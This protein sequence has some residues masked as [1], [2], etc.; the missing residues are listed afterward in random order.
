MISIKTSSLCFPLKK[1]HR[2]KYV[3][4]KVVLDDVSCAIFSKVIS[5]TLTYPLESVRLMS[6]CTDNQSKDISRLFYGV[7]TYLPYCLFGSILTYKLYYTSLAL[8]L[9]TLDNNTAIFIASSL[10]SIV[11]AQYKI[12]YGY[13]LKNSILKEKVHIKGLYNVPYYSKAFFATIMED[14]PEMYIK[15]L[16]SWVFE[17]YFP[18]INNIISS[19]GIAVVSSLVICPLE[20]LKTS[21]LCSTKKMSLT[22]EAILIRIFINI[23][24]TFL[25]FL[26]FNTL[27]QTFV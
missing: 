9:L 27:R 4:P 19:I 8:L 7:N 22:K 25:F 11:S 16:M 23:V 12:P 21:I 20:F 3:V 2:Y 17:A 13:L 10:T 5:N 26:S 24:N 6:L 1:T 15:F 14:I 18:M